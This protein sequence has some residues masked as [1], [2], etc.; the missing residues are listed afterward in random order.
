LAGLSQESIEATADVEQAGA[1]ATLRRRK[2]RRCRIM[3]M[4]PRRS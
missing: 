3:V 4:S 2:R 1:T